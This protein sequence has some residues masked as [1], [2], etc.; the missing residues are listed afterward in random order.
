MNFSVSINALYLKILTPLFFAGLFIFYTSEGSA[1]RNQPALYKVLTLTGEKQEYGDIPQ[2]HGLDGIWQK[3][4]KLQTTASVMHTQAHPDDEQADLLTYLGRGK[5]MRTSLLSLNRGE[6]GGNILG[7]ESFDQLALLRTEEFLLAAG[8]YGLDD[9]YFTN[10]VDYGFSKRVEE[11]YEKW[12]RQNVLSEMV[13][14]IRI[15]RP[16]VIIS[17]FHGSKRDG[18]GHHQAAG[19]ISPEAFKMAG[20]PNAFPEQ[21]TKEGLRP[22]KALKFYCGGIKADEHFNVALNTGEYCP[23]L[24]DSYKNF[25]LLGYSFHRSQNGGQRNQVIGAFTQ[26]YER[27]HSLV[28]SEEKEKTF[29]DGIDTS[30]MGIFKITGETA[31]D[32][33]PLLLTAISKAVDDAYAAFQPGNLTALIPHLTKGLAKTRD[34]LKLLGKQ[35]EALFMLQIKERQ[36]MDAIHML[37]GVDVQAI[38]MPQGTKESTGFFQPPPTMGFAVPGQTFKV[39]VS[40]LNSSI[41]PIAA[42]DI[43]LIGQNKWKTETTEM[44]KSLLQANDKINRTFNVTVPDNVKF[45]QPYYHRASLQENQYQYDDKG[46]ANLPDRQAALQVYISYLVN[47]ELVEIQKPVQVRQANLPFGYDKYTLKLA[48]A[49]AVNIQPR[50]GIIPKNGQVKNID[51][52]VE[53]INNQEGVIQGDLKL[54]LPTGWQSPTSHIP[55]TFTKA[56]EKNNFSFKVNIA[57]LKEKMYEIKAIATVNNKSYTQGYDLSSH[58]DLDQTIMYRPAIAVLKGIDVKIV[59]GLQIGYIMGVGDE[60]PMAIRQLGAS[61]QLLTSD[62]LST[63]SLD[64]F[65]AILIGTRAYAVRQDLLTYNMRLL[66]YAKNGGHLIV[67]FQTP[68]FIPDR[69][70]PYPAQLPSNSEEVSEENSPVKILEVNHRVFNY[71]NKIT[72]VD[73]DEWVEQRGSK[74]FS[75]WDK[76][77]IPLI[78][79]YDVGQSQQS[80]G[81]LMAPYGKGHYTYFAYSFHRQLPYGV[82]GAYRIL[83]NILSYGKN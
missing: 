58:R 60:V 1:Q 5:G 43:E 22:W 49:I 18:H 79:T 27:M 41:I 6:S 77:Y 29:F 82:E 53:L 11:A 7:K 65:D 75:H 31:P 24:G 10:L 46:D 36:F 80:G 71:P 34:A 76:T 74:F 32:D 4:L 68:E 12:G 16:L 70:A 50:M 54:N 14:V 78:S 19:E 3:L 33:V 25:S 38:A 62:D 2:N 73:F 64:G 21:I 83:A 15:N 9:L 28:N 52:Q 51:I 17:R 13:R 26:Y 48:P 55:F 59:P 63:G 23:W 44:K 81:W 20:D 39:G 37:L 42:K 57:P 66:E 69:M 45:S 30:I 61:V 47:N 56:G 40:L 8:Y 35:P 72:S 67:L